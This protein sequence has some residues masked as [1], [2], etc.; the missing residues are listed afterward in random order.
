[1]TPFYISK[2]VA[3]LIKKEEG[4]G[5]FYNTVITVGCFDYFHLG[6]KMLLARMKM[7][8]NK[9]IVGIHDSE[10]LCKIKGVSDVQSYRIREKLV[11]IYAD[12]TFK[13]K[14]TD[15]TNDMKRHLGKKKLTRFCYMRA[16][17][18]VKFPGEKYISGKMP[19]EY[20]PYTKGISSTDIR[21]VKGK[22]SVLNNLLA[23]V[24]NALKENNISFY[25]DCGTLLGCVRD[26]K[27]I[28]YDTDID[29]TVHLSSWKD[30]CEIDF[31]QYKLCVTR[32]YND[33]P[34]GAFSNMI[35]VSNSLNDIYCD[36]YCNPAFPKLCSIVFNGNVYSIPKD[37]ELYLEQLYGK[38]WAIPANVHANTRFHRHSGL[39]KSRYKINWDEN[40]DIY[41][42][43]L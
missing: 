11:S 16:D 2:Q 33:F 3:A 34:N 20:L 39:V 26:D 37:P 21:N 19:I 25:L 10:S 35:S 38:D 29:V 4:K 22:V 15:P 41:N 42:C 23:R 24:S 43:I 31:A 1:M 13:I 18:N 9:L 28:D 12:E 8:C 30:L 7:R 17:D 32:R 14:D 5:V 40:Y 27:I 6:H 36:I